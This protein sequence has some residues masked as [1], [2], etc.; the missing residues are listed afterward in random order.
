MENIQ[1]DEYIIRA[2]LHYITADEYSYGYMAQDIK[3]IKNEKENIDIDPITIGIIDE[4]KAIDI[5]SK[6]FTSIFE[7]NKVVSSQDQIL[8]K[9]FLKIYPYKVTPSFFL[10]KE[11]LAIFAQII[12]ENQKKTYMLFNY[13]P[14]TNFKTVTDVLRLYSAISNKSS[15]NRH[16]TLK[17]LDRQTRY[18]FLSYLNT[19]AKNK[20]DIMDDFAQHEVLWKKAFRLL[21]VGEFKS[22]YPYIYK[23]AEKL[24]TNQYETFFSK[25]NTYI[26]NNDKEVF[27]LLKTKPGFFARILDSLIR[28]TSFTID[29]IL[30]EFFIVCHLI[31]TNVL[32]QLWEYYQN[33][34]LLLDNRFIT[35]RSE[36]NFVSIKVNE[37]RSQY[38]INDLNKIINCIEEG[39]R[40]LYSFRP[41]FQDVYI[42][43]IMKNYMVP[44]NN[45]NQLEGLN[46]LIFGSKIKL[47]P[48]N[49]QILRFFT[50][51]KNVKN[52]RVDIDLSAE[53]YDDSFEYISSLAWHDMSGGRKFNSYHSG[54]ITSAPNGASEF[55]DINYLKAK[56]HC[57]YIVI[58]NTVYTD[59]HFNEIPECFSGIMFR[60]Q[61]GKK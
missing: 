21:H 53:L 47:S 48:E 23:C 29:E 59:Q 39:L 18:L 19:L 27:L 17:S 49:N 50:H 16:I 38:S 28:N 58:C 2:I 20:E 44:I 30:S 31:S 1:D 11:N 46:T 6:Y 34:N 26:Q 60:T 61:S 43:P 4:E 32:I 52:D 55:I 13:L 25:I 54:D 7:S 33:R 37:N 10:F 22:K 9:K 3:K 56:K 41:L 5:L 14:I 40:M 42:D 8:V 24:R 57:R 35:Y 45:K 36:F 51:W 12:L 15:L